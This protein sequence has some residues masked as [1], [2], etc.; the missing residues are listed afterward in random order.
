MEQGTGSRPLAVV[1]GASSGIGYHLALLAAS[2]G[3]DLLLAADTPLDQAVRDVRH[4]GAQAEAVQA[5]LATGDGVRELIAAVGDRQVD[6]LMA[7]AGHGLGGAFLEQRWQAIRHLIDTNIAGTLEL[8]H[9]LAPGMCLRAA[10]Q[11]PARILFTGSVAGLQPGAYEAVYA[12][13]KAFIDSFAMAL[14]E[15]LKGRPLTVTCLLPGPTD[16]GFF[17]RAGMLD[18]AVGRGPKSDPAKVARIGFKAMLAGEADVV[19]GWFNKMQAA[20]SRLAPGELTAR[21]HARLAEPRAERPGQ[22]PA[23]R[24]A[25]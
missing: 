5:D 10:G 17:A 3:C 21:M 6:M 12:A 23:G 8:V 20:A 15:E 7:N 11:P 4:A 19:A 16:T 14:R 2:H 13:S 25:E 24:N 1:T 18:T 9:A 22:A